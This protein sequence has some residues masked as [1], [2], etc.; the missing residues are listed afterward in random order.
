MI[1]RNI[2]VE[3]V[4]LGFLRLTFLSY[5]LFMFYGKLYMIALLEFFSV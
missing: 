5:E 3:F 2:N 4:V 1:F